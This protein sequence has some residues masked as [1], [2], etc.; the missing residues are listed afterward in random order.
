MRDSGNWS[1]TVFVVDDCQWWA[2]MVL[3]MGDCHLK[4]LWI[5]TLWPQLLYFDQ[6]DDF[7][8]FVANSKLILIFLWHLESSSNTTYDD[9]L[10]SCLN[11]FDFLALLWV[12]AFF[13][14]LIH[15]TLVLLTLTLMLLTCGDVLI[16]FVFVLRSDSRSSF[17]Q[18]GVFV[19][20]NSFIAFF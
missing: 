9:F 7:F 17:D 1:S 12:L 15:S 16:Y 13:D 19:R 2:S 10:E 6:F 14:V 18:L 8:R 20:I 3:V 4:N 11:V 5:I